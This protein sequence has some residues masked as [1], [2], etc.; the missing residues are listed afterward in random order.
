MKGEMPKPYTVPEGYVP[1]TMMEQWRYAQRR[2][3]NVLSFV[4]R[5]NFSLCRHLSALTGEFC[6]KQGR[7]HSCN[8][9]IP[10]R[11]MAMGLRFWWA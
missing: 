4:T 2:S 3:T 10:I 11:G 7:A 6:K 8:A 1:P 5:L 9:G